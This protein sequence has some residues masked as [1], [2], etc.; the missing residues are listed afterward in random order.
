MK[1]KFTFEQ[2]IVKDLKIKLPIMLTVILFMGI[3]LSVLI[4]IGWGT[5]PAS[6]MNLNIAKLFGWTLGNTQ[7]FTYSILF[8]FTILFDPKMIGF[9]T[10]ANM[11]LIGYIADFFKLVWNV[12]GF[13]EF[14]YSSSIYVVILFFI[15]ALFMFVIAASIY[16]N[17]NLGIA[18]YDAT[19][20]IIAEHCKLLPSFLIRMIFDFTAVGIGVLAG[21]FGPSGIQG[22]YIGSVCM[23]VLLGPVILLTG[24]IMRKKIKVFGE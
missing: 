18:P 19:P 14:I 17:S 10:L 5:D 1:N 11:F 13:A 24:K 7:V 9:G 21:V 12:T 22:S 2:F 23:S 6:F 16:I 8:I 4:L 20:V 3:T 15:L